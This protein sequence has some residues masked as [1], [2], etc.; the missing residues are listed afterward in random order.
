MF[1][2]IIEVAR[3]KFGKTEQEKEQRA[4]GDGRPDE[5]AAH[6]G[7]TEGTDKEQV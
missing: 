4:G 7:E 1:Y 6:R 5:I 2:I 3:Y